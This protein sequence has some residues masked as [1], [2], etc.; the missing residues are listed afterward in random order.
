MP[1][2]IRFINFPKFRP[3]AKWLTLSLTTIAY[4][5]EPKSF[6][7][8]SLVRFMFDPLKLVRRHPLSPF[9]RRGLQGLALFFGSI[10]AATLIM[11]LLEGWSLADSFYY[12]TMLTT[13]EG[14]SNSPAT[15]G[16]KL[17]ASFYSIYSVAL[18]LTTAT[19]MFGPMV[20]YTLRRGVEFF[21]KEKARLSAHQHPS[22]L[23][24]QQRP[25]EN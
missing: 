11:H 14:P 5:G 3:R 15:L 18:L 22:T 19:L 21:E 8:C 25:S 4:I 16:G 2:L 13:G 23:Q 20:G 9:S 24:G 6:F 7:A 1:T 17:F 12:I 10:V